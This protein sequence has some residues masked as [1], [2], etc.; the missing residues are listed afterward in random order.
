M[1]CEQASTVPTSGV[2]PVHGKQASK[3]DALRTAGFA[4]YLAKA[5][6]YRAERDSAKAAEALQRAAMLKPDDP[7]P[8]FQLCMI[9]TA[10]NDMAGAC[11][12]ALRCVS[13]APGKHLGVLPSELDGAAV[14]P[15]VY[16]QIGLRAAVMAFDLLIRA[17]CDAV[18]RPAWWADAPLLAMSARALADTPDS[19]YALSVRAHVLVG[20]HGAGGRQRGWKLG[21]RSA[22][23]LR[24]AATLL[25]RQALLEPAG[26]AQAGQALRRSA[27]VLEVA[28][29]LE[30]DEQRQRQ[31]QQQAAAAHATSG[32]GAASL[33]TSPAASPT[34]AS[35]PPSD[36]A[37]ALCAHRAQLEAQVAALEQQLSSSLTTSN[38]PAIELR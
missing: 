5:E 19:P 21:E 29:R 27:A 12:S 31:Q 23:Q 16:P 22:G 3:A 17:P 11:V 10:A 32:R 33:A 30:A 34:R 1:S 37:E 35:K 9:L 28:A 13:L 4:S 8:P 2:V 38:V 18:P 14:P 6:N 15:G 20:V 25:K 36:R 7:R 26:S 24:E